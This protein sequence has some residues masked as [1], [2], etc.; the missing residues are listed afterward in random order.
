MKFSPNTAPVL[1]VDDDRD[2][3]DALGQSLE[4]AGYTVTLAASYIVAVDHITPGFT[5]VVV[6]DIRMP[7]KDGFDLLDRCKKVDKDLP[8][9]FLTG[10]GDIAMAVEAIFAGAYDFLEK[11]CSPKR[12]LAS[13]GRAAEKRHLVL[14][15]RRL[16]VER[17]A[18]AKAKTLAPQSGLTAQMEM[19]EMLLIEDALRNHNG[20]VVEV[21][22]A[23]GLPKKTLYDKLARHRLNAADFRKN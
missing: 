5:G 22:Q 19:V 6:S 17:N 10:E 20:K 14:Q 8:V 16:E 2:V 11:P 12:L 13:V 18:V 1:L 7:G 4:L 23:L 15:N 3:R 9:I 21:A